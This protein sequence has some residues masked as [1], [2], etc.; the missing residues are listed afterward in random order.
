MKWFFSA[1]LSVFQMVKGVVLFY[2]SGPLQV[3]EVDIWDKEDGL[4]LQVSHGFEESCV[5]LLGNT[6]DTHTSVFPWTSV[7][8]TEALMK[9]LLKHFTSILKKS[10][11]FSFQPFDFLRKSFLSSSRIFL[12][13]PWKKNCKRIKLTK[14]IRWIETLSLLGFIRSVTAR[15]WPLEGELVS[16]LNSFTPYPFY[17]RQCC[18]W[19]GI[20][21]CK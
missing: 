4:R 1:A 17:S 10:F 5:G 12:S 2:L 21:F 15:R 16:E 3:A 14:W 8:E 20:V 9:T 18:S 6:Y 19:L 11:F 7:K 13:A